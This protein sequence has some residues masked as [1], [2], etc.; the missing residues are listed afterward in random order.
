MD[1]YTEPTHRM[2]MAAPD[3]TPLVGVLMAVMLVFVVRLPAESRVM[4]V[5]APWGGCRLCM[6][7]PCELPQPSRLRV[8][9]AGERLLDGTPVPAP[10][11]EAALAA[12][13]SHGHAAYHVALHIEDAAS[14]EDAA[15]AMAIVERAGLRVVLDDWATDALG[16]AG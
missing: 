2:P 11:L 16:A 15:R 4:P 7:G 1:S 13:A 14:L 8:T 5:D 10:A 6:S 9:A 3:V 12:E